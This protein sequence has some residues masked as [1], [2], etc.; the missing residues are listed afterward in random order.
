METTA[1]NTQSRSSLRAQRWM[2]RR[3]YGMTMILDGLTQLFF[4]WKT[5]LT[6]P[7]VRKVARINGMLRFGDS[8]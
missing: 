2:L 1:P 5:G 8:E 7:V 6:M 4:G 3:V